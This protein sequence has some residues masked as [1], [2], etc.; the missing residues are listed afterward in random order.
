MIACG[1]FHTCTDIPVYNETLK[2]K[3]PKKYG[4]ICPTNSKCTPDNL[5]EIISDTNSDSDDRNTDTG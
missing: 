1:T 2:M 5:T 3:H 4:Y